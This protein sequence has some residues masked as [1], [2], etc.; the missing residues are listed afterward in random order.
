M[1]L[2]RITSSAHQNQI[3]RVVG[4]EALGRNFGRQTA[5]DVSKFLVQLISGEWNDVVYFPLLILAA[6]GVYAKL[7]GFTMLLQQVPKRFLPK[8]VELLRLD[9]RFAEVETI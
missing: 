9:G 8:S 1:L 5:R 4:T 6:I 7:T 3:G 2:E